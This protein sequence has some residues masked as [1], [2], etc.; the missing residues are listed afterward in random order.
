[1]LEIE[2]LDY[3]FNIP[4]KLKKAVYPM[5]YVSGYWIGIII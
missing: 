2:V 5:S 4:D 3:E 1:M